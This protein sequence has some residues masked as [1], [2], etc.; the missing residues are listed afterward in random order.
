M[1]VVSADLAGGVGPVE[2]VGQVNEGEGEEA[3]HQQWAPPY[4]EERFLLLHD[5]ESTGGVQLVQL[6][7]PL[8]GR[9]V[10]QLDG[11]RSPRPGA[12]EAVRHSGRR[13]QQA[14][15]VMEAVQ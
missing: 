14:N 13:P 5:V 3:A 7:G 6:L 1:D 10:G 11:D 15:S 8:D 12:A 4:P 2:A 9:L